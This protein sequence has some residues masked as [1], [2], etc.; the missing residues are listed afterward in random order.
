L[1]RLIGSGRLVLDVEG[2]EGG[3]ALDDVR[4][5]RTLQRVINR[6]LSHI[7]GV[8]QNGW[9][10]PDDHRNS[11]PGVERPDLTPPAGVPVDRSQPSGDPIAEQLVALD[12]LRR[13]GI[14][15][16]D[17]FATKKAELLRRM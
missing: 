15:T 3:I 12:Q 10:R 2:E 17:E 7:D 16:E 13:R 14:V 11:R 1:E 4:R 6:Q 5:P 8:V 9:S